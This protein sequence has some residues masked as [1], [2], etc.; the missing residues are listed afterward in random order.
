MVWLEPTLRP[1]RIGDEGVQVR[2]LFDLREK[3][4]G[5]DLPPVDLTRSKG[6]RR[7]IGVGHVP[8]DHLVEVCLLTARRAARCLIARDV[9]GIAYVHGLAT[10]LPLV[11]GELERPGA[12]D[13]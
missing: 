13:L 10:R 1:E 3:V 8:P 9:V 2:I 11:P 12:D 7:L 4:V 6:R 5:R